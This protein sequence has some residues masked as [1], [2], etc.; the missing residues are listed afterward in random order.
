MVGYTLNL[1]NLKNLDKK[2]RS[3]NLDVGF[4]AKS[5]YAE[6]AVANEYGAKIERK[7]K[8]GGSKTIIIPPRA[9]MQQTF[10]NNGKKWTAI[11][12][13]EIAKGK[14]LKEAFNVLGNI[15]RG[16]IVYTIFNGKFVD[17][18]PSTEQAKGFN[19]PLVNTGDMS[20]SITFKVK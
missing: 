9:F 2:Y 8:S 12:T 7:L 5:E 14:T 17:N 4:F 6:I 20:R 11:I 10:D 16:Q 13:N 15:I 18:A 3:S 1:K 19:K